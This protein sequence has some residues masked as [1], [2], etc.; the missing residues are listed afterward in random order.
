MIIL[1]LSDSPADPLLAEEPAQSALAPH[2][3]N[4]ERRRA[5]IAT[6][7]S[8]AFS[9]LVRTSRSGLRGRCGRSAC[10]GRSCGSFKRDYDDLIVLGVQSASFRPRLG[11]DCLFH[12]KAGWTVLLNDSQRAVPL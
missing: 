9:R 7:A 5:V 4:M 2:H 11:L 6:T 3:Q 12:L 8:P 1:S 10:A